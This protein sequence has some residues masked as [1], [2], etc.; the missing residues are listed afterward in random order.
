MIFQTRRRE[1]RV[2][3]KTQRRTLEMT[4]CGHSLCELRVFVKRVL[5]YVCVSV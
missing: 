1:R 4:A 3:G 5:G 2:S